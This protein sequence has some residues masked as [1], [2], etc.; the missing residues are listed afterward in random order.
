MSTS[1][2]PA[3]PTDHLGETATTRRHLAH[4]AE[5]DRRHDERLTRLGA[6]MPT[7]RAQC[8]ADACKGLEQLFCKVDEETGQVIAPGE[9]EDSIASAIESRTQRL[10]CLLA[11]DRR[12][13]AASAAARRRLMSRHG[14]AGVSPFVIAQLDRHLQNGAIG[15]SARDVELF[16]ELERCPDDIRAVYLPHGGFESLEFLRWEQRCER[17]TGVRSHL[18]RRYEDQSRRVVVAGP[19]PS[20]TRAGTRARGSGRPKARACM[21]AR[22]GDSS[23]D[24][25]PGEPSAAAPIR[26]GRR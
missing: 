10:R 2:G 18:V 7:G 25:S 21:S 20:T 1:P 4:H 23:D 16:A 14:R 3:R 12:S 11:Q 22:S 15:D 9:C 13:P 17:R 19:A 8:I 26:G 24:G 6:R 5:V